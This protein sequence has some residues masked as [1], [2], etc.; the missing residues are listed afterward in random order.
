MTASPI[1]DLFIS[2][3]DADRAWVDQSVVQDTLLK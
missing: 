3:V 1:Y 2:Y